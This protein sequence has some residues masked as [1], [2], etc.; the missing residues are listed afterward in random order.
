MKEISAFTT[1]RLL[2]APRQLVWDAWTKHEH[3]QKWFMPKGFSSG[4]TELDFRPGGS[5]HYSMITPDGEV[6]WG[7]WIFQKI[8]PIERLE[9]IDSFSD[10]AGG[11]TRHP[12]SPTWPP[13]M[14]MV[15]TLE[16]QGKQT[17][18]TI[19]WKPY[20]ASD[21]EIET[22]NA[23]HDSMSNGWAGTFANLEEYL[24]AIQS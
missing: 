3:L 6:M 19:N 10:E 20:N 7:K 11:I 17:K 21:E 15:T 23:S 9:V 24:V 18:L 5:Y 4:K 22:F 13:Q 12:L 8:D 16:D 1:T 2:K 14:L